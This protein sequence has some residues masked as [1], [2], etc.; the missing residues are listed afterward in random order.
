MQ[1]DGT[2]SPG[3]QSLTWADSPTLGQVQPGGPR[4]QRVPIVEA[5]QG[6]QRELMASAL[7]Y[8][9]AAGSIIT[10]VLYAV[11]GHP[12]ASTAGMLAVVCVTLALGVGIEIC[13]E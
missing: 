1:S 5:E 13:A 4:H 3:M 8:L 10:L 12:E 9:F 7:A 11:L 6:G 2:D